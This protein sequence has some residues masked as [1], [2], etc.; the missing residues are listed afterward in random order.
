M[1]R[2]TR[3]YLFK[4]LAGSAALSVLDARGMAWAQQRLVVKT[5][6]GQWNV[7]ARETAATPFEKST[8]ASVTLVAV[9][10]VEAVAKLKASTGS[11][12]YDV[13]LVDEGPRNQ[14]IA[15]GLLAPVPLD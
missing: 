10:S 3:R 6:T 11:P 13:L 9:N 5:F 12:P 15:E 8:G 7:G 4:S 2:P 1:L 14:A